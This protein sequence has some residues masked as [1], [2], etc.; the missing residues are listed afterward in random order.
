MY[1]IT[2]ERNSDVDA[3]DL[4]LDQAF[5]PA[6]RLK[7]STDLRK[8]APPLPGLDLVARN[9]A[10]I[11]GTVRAGRVSIGAGHSAVMLGP[12]AVSPAIQG[13]GIGS[14]LVRQFLDS[15]A[16]ANHGSVLLVGDIDF[17]GRFGFTHAIDHGIRLEDSGSRLLIKGLTTAALS[18]LNGDVTPWRCVRLL[19][20]AA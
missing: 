8:I 19:R 20:A 12:L 18:G 11:I 2:P 15:A 16:W 9:D 4:L 1:S 3:V 17:Y 7:P 13:Q 10:Q 6:W 14:T 5:G